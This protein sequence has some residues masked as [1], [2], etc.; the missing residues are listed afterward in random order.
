MT[1]IEEVIEFKT[2]N[3]SGSYADFTLDMTAIPMDHH[4]NE[5]YEM[6]L[7]NGYIDLT[8]PNISAALGNNTLT[9]LVPGPNTYPITIPDGRYSL[10][11][12]NNVIEQTAFLA[13]FSANGIRFVGDTATG[14]ISIYTLAGYTVTLP[15]GLAELLG[16]APGTYGT[17]AN[18]ISIGTSRPLLDDN[19]KYV[20][21]VCDCV[22]NNKIAGNGGLFTNDGILET[23]QYSGLSSSQLSLHSDTLTW[24]PMK[25]FQGH[26]RNMRF[27]VLD[28]DGKLVKMQDP[29]YMII[30]FRIIK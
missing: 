22:K 3:T 2:N 18:D 26:V 1:D 16:F 30:G 10:Y 21:V 5:E 19:I 23:I 20:N 27:R 7:L 17:I 15:T 4:N 28:Q 25:K 6:V 12:L 9:I 13:G 24:R 8:T 14:K 11:E 29:I